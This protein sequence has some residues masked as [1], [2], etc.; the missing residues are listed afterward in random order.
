MIIFVFVKTH[1]TNSM[2][3]ML[4]NVIYNRFNSCLTVIVFFFVVFSP[5]PLCSLLAQNLPSYLPSMV[6]SP[7]SFVTIDNSVVKT[8]NLI[9]QSNT[10][11]SSQ[12]RLKNNA[13][14]QIDNDVFF[15][16]T[17]S[18][19]PPQQGK[20]YS[21]AVPFSVDATTGFYT[22]QGFQLIQN[23][24]FAL[25]VYNGQTRADYGV[26][27]SSSSQNAFQTTTT[28]YPGVGYMIS[29]AAIPSFRIKASN[30]NEL[31][32]L[33]S[34]EIELY[35]Y[36]SNTAKGSQHE[37][38][39]FIA[40][41]LFVNAKISGLTGYAQVLRA[42]YSNVNSYQIIPF[43]EETVIAPYTAFFVQSP[44]NKLIS[45]DFFNSTAHSTLRSIG[46]TQQPIELFVVRGNTEDFD[47]MYISLN[48]YASDSYEIGK[49]V[50]KMGITSGVVQ[51]W[52]EEF[53]TQLAVND[54]K[55]NNDTAFLKLGIQFPFSGNYTIGFVIPP[56]YDIWLLKNGIPIFNLKDGNFSFESL[57]KTSYEYSLQI[58]DAYSNIITQKTNLQ[59]EQYK[60]YV[61]NNVLH[62]DGL[63]VG[64][65]YQVYSNLGLQLSSNIVCS[66]Q[67]QILLPSKGLYF[68]KISDNHAIKIINY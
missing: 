34:Q 55:I 33:E 68:L 57:R 27:N 43:D 11:S 51:L 1:K 42:G 36:A 53:G 12:F 35:Q 45:F 44:E 47:R 21:F 63:D 48:E 8:P 58:T 10:I 40:H 4:L 29:S 67:V 25:R 49:D 38:W 16:K 22:P 28:L 18:E 39:N 15:D 3:P 24:N 37:G 31:S 62:L 66:S 17:I 61:A 7:S 20:W 14:I 56:L 65:K 23:T 5:Q 19:N 2:L 64:V 59:Q 46:L 50:L 9:F 32:F 6:V 54:V 60:I 13:E 26:V 52:S 41:P 30:K